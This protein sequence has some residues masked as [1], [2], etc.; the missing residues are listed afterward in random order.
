[1]SDRR[2]TLAVLLVFLLTAP[3]WAQAPETHPNG[4]TARM[5]VIV[6]K[7][8]GGSIYKKLGLPGRQ[9]CWDA[10]LKEERCSG[11]RWG[12][13]GRDTAGMCVLL[14]GPL[15]FK[16]LAELKTEDGNPIHVVAA[17]KEPT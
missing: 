16:A 12:V 6:G 10:C 8:V 14:S 17:R 9:F 2:S 1:V 4:S 7:D 3:A 11:V 5:T 13:V 15:E